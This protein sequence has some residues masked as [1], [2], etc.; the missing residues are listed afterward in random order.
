MKVS[1]T[2]SE[3]FLS[4]WSF[5]GLSQ[6]PQMRFLFFFLE[7]IKPENKYIS[8]T[9]V[10]CRWIASPHI[11]SC[12]PTPAPD[13][14]IEIFTYTISAAVRSRPALSRTPAAGGVLLMP[15]GP[16]GNMI[17]LSYS[18]HQLT[19]L[20]PLIHQRFIAEGL[21]HVVVVAL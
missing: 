4:L 8:Q 20:S 6:K 1:L 21:L 16:V 10:D 9:C 19:K 13:F 3:S 12:G 7:P 11:V 5:N 18:R 14:H 2:L 17:N 15:S